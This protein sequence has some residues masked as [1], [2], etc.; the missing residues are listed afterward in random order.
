MAQRIFK[1]FMGRFLEAWYRLSREEQSHLRLKLRLGG[2]GSTELAE[3][4]A[5][6]TNCFVPQPVI[7]R[8]PG[9]KGKELILKDAT[10]S[11]LGRS[12]AVTTTNPNHW[13]N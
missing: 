10:F 11:A 8:R 2:S 13:R 4:L 7:A 1:I 9:W 3:V 5:L 12:G 6:S